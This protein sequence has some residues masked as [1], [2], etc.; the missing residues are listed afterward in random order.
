MEYWKVPP[1][2]KV[3]EALGA[4]ADGRVKLKD[5]GAEVVSSDG[6]RKYE[7]K[8]RP[9]DR[10]L[11]TDNGSLYKGYLGYPAIAFL[12]LKGLLPYDAELAERLRGV[13]WKELNER[14]KKYHVVMYV[15]ARE[16]GIDMDKM[17]AF[18]KR[19]KEGIKRKWRR[20]EG[21]ETEG[22]SA[23]KQLL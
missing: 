13:P 8:F 22:E 2:I 9:P 11:S 3:W 4:I 16:R 20:L 14:Y 6:S 7:V 23:E 12:M 5:G 15:V 18:V 1:D 10:I 19:V 17:K 21:E